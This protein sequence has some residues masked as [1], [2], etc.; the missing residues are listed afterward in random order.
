MFEKENICNKER[1][2]TREMIINS[3]MRNLAIFYPSLNTTVLT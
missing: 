1:R 3:V 2:S